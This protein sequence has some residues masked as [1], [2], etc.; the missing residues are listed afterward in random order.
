VHPIRERILAG[1]LCRLL[2]TKGLYVAGYEGPPPELPHPTDT[3]VFWCNGS[4]WAM[5]PDG[6]PCNPDRCGP[7]RGCFEPEIEA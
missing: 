5:G 4:G 7:G 3:A 1:T 6:L 2:R